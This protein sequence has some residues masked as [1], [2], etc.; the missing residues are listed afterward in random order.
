MQ[1]RALN[2]FPFSSRGF[3]VYFRGISRFFARKFF[4]V[5]WYSRCLWVRDI[6]IWGVVTEQN[7]TRGFTGC[8]LPKIA[9]EG[10]SKLRTG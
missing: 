10:G 2:Y 8:K 6:G 5:S 7:S 1:E 9:G 3:P 4:N